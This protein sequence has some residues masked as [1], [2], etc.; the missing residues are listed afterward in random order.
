MHKNLTLYSSPGVGGPDQIRSLLAKGSGLRVNPRAQVYTPFS[1]QSFAMLAHVRHF[2]ELGTQ[3]QIVVLP[4]VG[5]QNT[6]EPQNS[7]P[8]G[9]FTPLPPLGRRCL[10][11]QFFMDVSMRRSWEEISAGILKS[12][13][14]G[15]L[16]ISQLMATQNL[17]YKSLMSH[18]E[19][20]IS[21]GFVEMR[22]TG[23]RRQFSTTNPG[24]EAWKSYR[25]AIALLRSNMIRS[26]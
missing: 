25:H 6:G 20:L 9:D 12:C 8:V 7:S 5:S 4:G 3:F 2:P 1:W 26:C 15:S 11:I 10:S 23:R 14:A 17:T 21:A 24:V 18:L 22:K 19:Q 13:S 16:T